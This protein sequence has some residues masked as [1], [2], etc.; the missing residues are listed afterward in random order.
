MKLI[1]PTLHS[2][3][4]HSTVGVITLE[5]DIQEGAADADDFALRVILHLPLDWASCLGALGIPTARVERAL[6]RSLTCAERREWEEERGRAQCE[7]LALDWRERLGIAGGSRVTP[8]QWED[9]AL[10]FASA[11]STAQEQVARDV[12]LRRIERLFAEL[13][14]R[15]R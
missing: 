2:V 10:V 5:T 8:A 7:V 1:N 13:P 4:I 11:N 15:T 9:L 14:D 3:T 12:A 6:G